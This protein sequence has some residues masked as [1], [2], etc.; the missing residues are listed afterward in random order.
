MSEI[1]TSLDMLHVRMERR[2][3]ELE[4]SL[5]EIIYSKE[6]GKRLKKKKKLTDSETCQKVERKF[7]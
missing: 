4:S 5:I 7:S 6:Q 2:T 1:K 3:S